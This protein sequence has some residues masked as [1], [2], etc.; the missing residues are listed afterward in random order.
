MELSTLALGS[1]FIARVIPGAAAELKRW[2]RRAGAIPHAAVRREALSSIDAKA[3]HVHGGCILGTFLRGNALRHYIRLVATYETAVDYLDNLCDRM[4]TH[5]EEDF[6]ALHES[7]GDV[8]ATPG[9]PRR[10]F[11]CRDYDDG[12]YL[13]EL[14]ETSQRLFAQ[15]PGY[16]AVRPYAVDVADRYCELQARKHLNAGERER[17]CGA[18]FSGVAPDLAWWEG[19]AASGSTMPIFALAYGT[20]AGKISAARIRELHGGYFPYFS[21]THILLDYFIDQAEDRAH[22]ELNFVTC[23]GSR[24]AA[25][26]G[27]TN[28]ARTAL[29]RLSAL[30]DA[31]RHEFALR[32][33]CAFYCSRPKVARQGL[34]EDA[35]AIMQ[36]VDAQQLA[37]AQPLLRLYAK[38]SG[39]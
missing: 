32:A 27:I 4:D 2:R 26:D 16:E 25:R 38:L 36:A 20:L 8:F 24:Q 7:L 37:L 30:E 29:K 39:T 9:H 12:G 15:L 23:Y 18:A 10:Y 1:A 11:R 35:Q 13:E 19:A 31:Q 14:V 21:A 6:R 5:D 33:M 34:T 28:I 22:D 3:F 17:R